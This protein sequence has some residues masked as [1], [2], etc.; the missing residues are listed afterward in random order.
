MLRTPTL[1]PVTL[2]YNIRPLCLSL[3]LTP[4]CLR[5]LSRFPTVRC[6][7]FPLILNPLRLWFHH[8]FVHL[9]PKDHSQLQPDNRGRRL[10]SPTLAATVAQ[11]T[12][13]LIVG[14]ILAH[15]NTTVLT[16]YTKPSLDNDPVVATA[17]LTACIW[18]IA[19][20]LVWTALDGVSHEFDPRPYQPQHH[21]NAQSINLMLRNLTKKLVLQSL[22]IPAVSIAFALAWWHPTRHTTHWFGLYTTLG[23]SNAL[24]ALYLGALE[25]AL[26]WLLFHPPADWTALVAQLADDS[27]ME[28]QL[29][30]L[31]Y[32]VLQDTDIVAE[33]CRPTSRPGVTNLDTEE[34]RRQERLIRDMSIFLS[35]K[36]NRATPEVPLEEDV[37]RLTILESLGGSERQ[38]LNA[39]ASSARHNANVRA[40]VD[41]KLPKNA[42]F[43]DGPPEPL[44]VPLVRA[45]CVY[46][47]GLG[48]TLISRTQRARSEPNNTWILPPGM[49]TCADWALRALSRCLIFSLTGPDEK[50]LAD[51]HSTHVAMLVPAAMQ[52]IYLLRRGCQ[53]FGHTTLVAACDDT[54]SATIRCLTTT[55]RGRVD[56][57]GLEPEPLAWVQSLVS[58]P[59][60]RNSQALV[61][62]VSHKME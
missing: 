9:D 48:E 13:A 55:Y 37:L 21:L 17:I 26:R 30:V 51:W 20:P 47:G 36:S 33:V 42:N 35:S 14:V 23:L 31:L 22:L 41:W 29:G 39:N 25:E 43:T 28:R 8:P 32:S 4:V 15:I 52:A 16:R 1:S 5:L 54:A 10:Q 2:R 24:V 58:A 44:I 45:L 6:S 49:L 57:V 38:P 18:T 61:V 62:S 46:I 27:S 50:P 7:P 11:C 3:S 56:L 60:S 59:S 12:V 19:G 34:S 53:Q 40:W